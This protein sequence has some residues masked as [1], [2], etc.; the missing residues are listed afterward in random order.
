MKLIMPRRKKNLRYSQILYWASLKHSDAKLIRPILPISSVR[1]WPKAA[2]QISENLLL[3]MTALGES[4][5]SRLLPHRV[6]D[7]Y[8]MGSFSL[9]SGHSILPKTV[10]AICC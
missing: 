10:E 1:F 9:G 2:G 4:R 7:L 5:R 8:G 3:R 6:I